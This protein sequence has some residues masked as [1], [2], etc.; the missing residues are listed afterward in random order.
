MHRRRLR[1]THDV[2]GDSLVGIATE[3]SDFEISV[4]SIERVAQSRR[5]LSRFLVTEHALVPGFTGEPVCFLAR[6]GRAL[7]RCSDRTAVDCLSQLGAHRQGECA[8][9]TDAGKPLRIGFAARPYHLQSRVWTMWPAIRGRSDRW[10]GW[11]SRRDQH[12]RRYARKQRPATWQDFC[13]VLRSHREFFPH[14]EKP[15]NWTHPVGQISDLN[16]VIT[17]L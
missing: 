11:A 10:I 5:R 12:H 8:R 2:E 7:R 9:W 13:A 3:A 1:P 14:S 15:K 6:L 16:P 17:N 4:S